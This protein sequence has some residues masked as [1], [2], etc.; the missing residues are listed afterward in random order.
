MK[1]PSTSAHHTA[2]AIRKAFQNPSTSL[3]SRIQSFS[4]ASGRRTGR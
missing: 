4:C 3:T 2:H 1:N